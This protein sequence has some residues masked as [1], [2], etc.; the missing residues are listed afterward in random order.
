MSDI[1][2]FISVR[3]LVAAYPD[4]KFI[5]T[6]REPSA[7]LRS[8]SGSIGQA[9]RRTGRFPIS[10][11]RWF[12]HGLWCFIQMGTA[13][14]FALFAGGDPTDAEGAMRKYEEQYAVPPSAGIDFG[15]N[16]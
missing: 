14:R 4:A 1:P 5:L 7:W 13:M 11:L 10:F 2:G 16:N 9:M 3:D 6:T 8:V 15:M 12:D